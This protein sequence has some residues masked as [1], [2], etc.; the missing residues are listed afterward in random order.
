VTSKFLRFQ[1]LEVE[2]DECIAEIERLR[3]TTGSAGAVVGKLRISTGPQSVDPSADNKTKLRVGKPARPPKS[4]ST[5]Q[6][7][8]G[9]SGVA[10]VR[11]EWG[12]TVLPSDHA[13]VTP[14][15]ISDPDGPNMREG[16]VS[17]ARRRAIEADYYK[18]V[19]LAQL[20]AE[21]ELKENVRIRAAREAKKMRLAA[22]QQR[23]QQEMARAKV[24]L[25]LTR[26]PVMSGLRRS[27]EKKQPTEIDAIAR[28]V[29]SS[30]DEHPNQASIDPDHTCMQVS[31][32]PNE[33]EV[34]LK[35]AASDQT[36]EGQAEG[37]RVDKPASTDRADTHASISNSFD[38]ITEAALKEVRTDLSTE[39]AANTAERNRQVHRSSFPADRTEEDPIPATES[40]ETSTTAPPLSAETL[41]D[42]VRPQKDEVLSEAS[43]AQPNTATY[44]IGD[45]ES[46]HTTTQPQF[47]KPDIDDIADEP[48]ASPIPPG[49]PTR[50]DKSTD[51]ENKTDMLRMYEEE[52]FD[53]GGE[54]EEV[55][56]SN[57]TQV[58]IGASVEDDPKVSIPLTEDTTETPMAIDTQ[59]NTADGLSDDGVADADI[60]VESS[61]ATPE[62][63]SER[64]EIV[65]IE[66]PPQEDPLANEVTTPQVIG[67]DTTSSINDPKQQRLDVPA[68]DETS[69]DTV[70]L[71]HDVGTKL[72]GDVTAECD[73]DLPALTVPSQ[74][75]PEQDIPMEA[76]LESDGEGN[77]T[78]ALKIT[79]SPTEESTSGDIA[80]EHDEV[81]VTSESQVS[82]DPVVL[83]VP[84]QPSDAVAH[85]GEASEEEIDDELHGTEV[86]GGIHV[87]V[88]LNAHSAGSE[89]AKESEATITDAVGRDALQA[90]PIVQESDTVPDD[91]AIESITIANDHIAQ[92]E[93]DE[94]VGDN[95]DA[96]DADPAAVSTPDPDDSDDPI[97]ATAAQPV[98]LAM[99]TPEVQSHEADAPT[100]R[101]DFTPLATTR[102]TEDSDEVFT[103]E[104]ASPRE[105]DD[106]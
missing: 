7:S 49:A 68:S 97:S 66:F 54:E 27:R 94:V 56:D 10:L 98:Q 78:H 2:I 55:K 12:S 17:K 73:E 104:F 18:Q 65:S 81:E 50:D 61:N 9:E 1:E 52:E 33:V 35:R 103:P 84:A 16:F 92:A 88:L 75:E 15:E 34:N 89:D 28:A 80:D 77:T 36:A 20:E 47:P 6:V 39:T 79:L 99:D 53:D 22:E 31:S 26:S 51:A 19:R 86:V 21:C 64:D 63:P 72:A 74:L 105:E 58:N 46:P 38:A 87:G 76:K 40:A 100:P 69:H 43:T 102:S 24:A 3:R 29:S 14:H 59:D 44:Y 32:T 30:N 82:S 106:D 95:D 90:T 23:Q 5:N 8:G 70:T 83:D 96:T 37:E 48:S 4:I 45:D 42:I 60:G 85:N 13:R 57:E 67:D 25:A 91:S 11:D 93:D 101:Y 71:I 62:E 41:L